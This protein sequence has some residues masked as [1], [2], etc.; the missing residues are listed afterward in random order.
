MLLS[1]EALKN[2]IT[3]ENIG[4]FSVAIQISSLFEELTED[5]KEEELQKFMKIS[6][7]PGLSWGG[8]RRLNDDDEDEEVPDMRS[9]TESATLNSTL[10]MM[11]L[12]ID[13]Q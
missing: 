6:A 11:Q 1:P 13:I 8:R 10:D 2:N 5:E 9:F 7:N 4:N 12:T 3:Q